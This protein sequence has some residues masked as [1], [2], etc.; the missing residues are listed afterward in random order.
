[1]GFRKNGVQ[2]FP[3]APHPAIARNN[4]ERIQR[5]YD[6]CTTPG[7]TLEYASSE[8]E[9]GDAF[10]DLFQTLLLAVLRALH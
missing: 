3:K 10:A 8:A 5:L 2:P 7:V 9:M 1:M 4:L 6:D